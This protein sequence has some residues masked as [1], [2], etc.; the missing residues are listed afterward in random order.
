M[1]P[2]QWGRVDEVFAAALDCPPEQWG[3]YLAAVD[4]PEVSGEVQALLLAHEGRGRLDSIADQL[5]GLRPAAA[6]VPLAALL[7][8]LR[9]V[10]HDR[11]RVERE[12]GRGGMAIVLLAEDL[13][14]RR[15]VAVKVLQP[16]LS[17]GIGPER[18]LR[19]IAI[20]ARLAHPHILP[21][22]DSGEADGLLYYVMP[23]VEGES[24]RD[25]LRREGRLPLK[26][27]LQ[28]TRQVSDALSYAHRCGVIH[29]DIKPE[30]ILFEAGHAVVSDFGIALA[31]TAAGAE[32]TAERGG[33][34]LGTPAYMSPE[35]AAG[36]P[37][38]G[39]SDI[40]SLGCVLYE[41]V[42]GE[43]PFAGATV[44]SVVRRHVA[45][46]PPVL[47]AFRAGIPEAVA[48]TLKRALAKAPADRFATAMEFCD[49]LPPFGAVAAP[50]RRRVAFASVAL[51]VVALAI[52]AV[53]GRPR[54]A[55]HP[56]ASVIAVLPPAP[57]TPDTVLA[58][59]GHDLVIT[60]SANLNGV[61]DLRAIDPLTM[62]AQTQ[63]RSA[64]YT[65]DE[66]AALSRRLGASG[67]ITG[68]LTRD[69]PDDVRLDLGLYTASGATAVARAFVTG[70]LDDINALTDSATW[71]LLRQVW[72][73]GAA[74]TPS[75]ASITTRSIPAL[76][77][78]LEGERAVVEDRWPEAEMAFAE[79]VEED[80]TF[81]IAHWRLAYAR[82]WQG[83]D[84]DS[85]ALAPALTHAAQLPE[86]ERLLMEA[87]VARAMAREQ[88]RQIVQRYPDYWF[89]WFERADGLFHNG[90]FFGQ[91]MAEARRA[92]E[93]SV[94]LAPRVKA[95]WD[96]LSHVAMFER[97]PDLLEQALR[98]LAKDGDN[99]C[100]L[101]RRMNLDLLRGK[102]FAGPR[103]DSCVAFALTLREPRYQQWLGTALGGH[104]AAQVEFSRR[105]LRAGAPPE[106]ADVHRLGLAVA[107]ATR[108]AWDSALAAM[109]AYAGQSP[110]PSAPLDLYRFAVVGAWLGGLEP[111]EALA[112]RAGVHANRL[113]ANS[114]PLLLWLDGI[115][116]VARR[117]TVALGLAR[118]QLGAADTS[119]AGA[120]ARS[121]AAFENE[122][123]GRPRAAAESLHAMAYDRSSWRGATFRGVN[124]LAAARWL[125]AAGDL[126]RA[127]PLL[128]W[129][130]A[131]VFAP[132]YWFEANLLS[133]VTY[134]EAA[135]IEAARGN[136]A[137]ARKYYQEF[138]L[139]YDEPVP[140][141]RHL[142]KEARAEVARLE[143]R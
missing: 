126:D 142:V 3:A 79:A 133:G 117:D 43:A 36:E 40:F 137:Q 113:P 47:T 92:F 132:Q 67:V 26:D 34:V 72:R 136:A 10:L 62:L 2:Q 77:A 73:S 130:Q 39:R 82:G 16:D 29:R 118:R 21:L 128:L 12:L 107:W 35:Q 93:R 69:G 38:D 139:R 96:H 28:I 143:R 8:R 24:L 83:A 1:T 98:V 65:L 53:L 103:A 19:E 75:L 114:S 101:L 56:A 138:L 119:D 14:H 50:A 80:S 87:W 116:A 140:P 99:S 120:F 9:G 31:V 5:R 15:H 45:K 27:A 91:P 37:L 102:P 134:L 60:L 76:R 66:A 100:C 131:A 33:M 42:V 44:Q 20:A 127:G 121:L 49:A 78:F 104:P 57:V 17:H 109:D 23:Y 95:A 52:G 32:E 48:A 129:P 86:P 110:D 6:A 84:L 88:G 11:Y 141:L 81:W 89:G 85:A 71:A 115:L 97:D 70:P 135:R 46:E 30:N 106:A 68:T 63:E 4:D 64:E 74:P 54:A 112:Q 122:L 90:P 125:A 111:A 123:R 124:R 58:R 61:G 51:I 41:M 105:V 22:H 7:E 108:G 13:R 25:R 55:A 18:F 59:L 94:E